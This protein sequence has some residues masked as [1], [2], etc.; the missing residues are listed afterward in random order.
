MLIH[1]IVFKNVN[2][3]SAQFDK[4]FK[5][6]FSNPVLSQ[7]EQSQNIAQRYSISMENKIRV[8]SEN[9]GFGESAMSREETE[10]YVLMIEKSNQKSGFEIM[11]KMQQKLI[12][13]HDAQI[14]T[15]I[16]KLRTLD[17][18][19]NEF[20]VTEAEIAFANAK[21]NLTQDPNFVKK[22]TD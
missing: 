1:E 22:V 9:P 13:S 17:T 21:Y 4:A 3:P 7:A 19:Y 16:S 15:E 12:S 18:M 10:T 5:N 11:A 20:A 14:A 8:K 6:Y 2:V